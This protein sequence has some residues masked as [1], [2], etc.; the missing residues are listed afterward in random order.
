MQVKDLG[1]N[2]P[3]CNVDRMELLPCKL[4]PQPHFADGKS[5]L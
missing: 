3:I 1:A 4:A 5:L 2:N